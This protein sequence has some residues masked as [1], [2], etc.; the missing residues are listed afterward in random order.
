MTSGFAAPINAAPSI[1]PA[2]EYW[3]KD[4]S[5]SP[6]TSDT[7]PILRSAAPL[8]SGGRLIGAGLDAGL[9]DCAA[10]GPAIAASETA[11]SRASAPRVRVVC[12]ILLLAMLSRAA[13]NPGPPNATGTPPPESR[14]QLSPE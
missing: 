8:A 1:A 14:R 4:L 3:L 9:S 10:T 5:S 11:A 13:G 2:Y 7:T 12:T 6:P